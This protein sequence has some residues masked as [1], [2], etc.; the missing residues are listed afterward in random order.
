MRLIKWL[1]GTIAIFLLIVLG[2]TNYL[3]PDS[4]RLCNGPG[5]SGNC[6][7]AD[8]IVV[9]VVVIQRRALPKR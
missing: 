6:A 8:A 5:G 1:L 7:K 3:G 9:I 2:I 4:L